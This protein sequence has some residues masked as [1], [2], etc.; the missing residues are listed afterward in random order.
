MLSVLMAVAVSIAAAAQS[1]QD[2]YQRALVQEHASGDLKR[3]ISLYEEAAKAAVNDRALAARALI[4]V[5]GA[6]E[7]LGAVVAAERRY[8][9]VLRAYPEQRTAVALAQQRLKALR[10]VPVNR[11]PERAPDGELAARLAR[12][13]WSDVP[14]A[15]LLEG[16]SLGE[17][18]DPI[19]LNRQVIRMLRDQR[20]AA[21]L[22][23]FFAPWLSLDKLKTAGLDPAAVPQLDDELL[24]SMATETRL[25]VQSQVRGDRDAVE[26]WTAPYTFVNER[27]ARHYG[28]SGI[29]GKDFR[30]VAWPNPN[31]AGLLGQAGPLTAHSM[32]VRTSPTA[33]GTFVM[34]SFLG[35]DVPAP[36]ANIPPLEEPPSDSHKTMRD[37]MMVHRTNPNCAGCHALF[38]PVGFALENFDATGRWRTT[39]GGSPIDASGTLRGA[40]FNGP[41][42]LRA[43]LLKYRTDYYTNI[44]QQL[45]AYSLKRKGK[46]GRV[47]G[48]EMPA[49]E[50]IVRDAS[51]HGYRWSSIIAGIAASDPFQAKDLV[52]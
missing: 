34:K 4:R 28:M 40:R 42:E 41:A 37:R 17:L 18:R 3:A 49:V 12:F 43:V 16:A 46:P 22:D 39:D 26:L 36:P 23:N 32:G 33:R 52:P 51:D 44:T 6:H 20:S 31:R 10:S 45:L 1:A 30:R 9:E 38:D 21:L 24:E 2:L 7:K 11:A 27:L 29:A 25:F 14:D 35:V 47:Y 19:G 5:A 8:A 50:Q 48:Y 15:R 13:L